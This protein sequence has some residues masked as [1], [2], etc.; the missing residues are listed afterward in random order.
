MT[1]LSPD[2]WVINRR[3]GA[4]RQ[5]PPNALCVWRPLSCAACKQP[6]TQRL[7]SITTNSLFAQRAARK[8]ADLLGDPAFSYAG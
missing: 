2:P 6:L 1:S 5:D 4:M 8:S 7:Y 3:G